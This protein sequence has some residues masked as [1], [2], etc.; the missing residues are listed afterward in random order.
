MVPSSLGLQSK[1]FALIT[2]ICFDY[3]P[4]GPCV[5]VSG[6]SL[7]GACLPGRHPKRCPDSSCPA[8][9]ADP[10]APACAL[11]SVSDS[12]KPG[13]WRPF[14][15][16]LAQPRRRRWRPATR[17][18]PSWAAVARA[19]R[20]AP[21]TERGAER[22]ATVAEVSAAR[23]ASGAA[24]E[25]G[26]A[27]GNRR[28]RRG[29]R[30][31]RG[32]PTPAGAAR[33]FSSR[34]GALVSAP[35]RGPAPRL[36]AHLSALPTPTPARTSPVFPDPAASFPAGPT[37]RGDLCHPA[38]ASVPRAAGRCF[39]AGRVL[40]RRALPRPVGSRQVLVPCAPARKEDWWGRWPRMP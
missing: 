16:S 10:A 11:R 26:R 3:E 39:P 33:Y 9:G 22:E 1:L 23:K 37:L 31:V 38:A 24:A 20:H 8:G 19:P 21:V 7:S 25:S 30:A 4:A 15:R 5:R 36:G 14:P 12:A 17:R 18:D 13:R 27:A 35:A 29:L 34:G 32:D 6:W 2:T 40:A 28:P